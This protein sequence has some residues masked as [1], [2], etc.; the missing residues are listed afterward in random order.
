MRFRIAAMK[1]VVSSSLLHL[2]S[3]KNKVSLLSMQVSK[4][5]ALLES[6]ETLLKDK[7]HHIWSS[8]L[9]TD[10]LRSKAD[11]QVSCDKYKPYSFSWRAA[12]QCSPYTEGC[13]G[14]F[15]Y[16]TY[17]MF[18]EVGVPLI[19]DWNKDCDINVYNHWKEISATNTSAAEWDARQSAEQANLKTAEHA[20]N[21]LNNQASKGSG[22]A[23]VDPLSEQALGGTPCQWNSCY[24]SENAKKNLVFASDYN[25]IGG[26]SQGGSEEW[27]KRHLHDH[28]PVVVSMN[29]GVIGNQFFWHTGETVLISEVEHLKI[30]PRPDN[31]N[32]RH[33]AALTHAVI[34][35]GYGEE[36]MTFP[37]SEAPD[38]PK[39]QASID[40]GN[41]CQWKSD[42][43]ECECT[44]TVP[45][46]VSFSS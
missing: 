20:T 38:E 18:H 29:T 24:T 15:S 5:R 44:V 25:Y 21:Q 37:D 10:E 34:A 27:I 32:I 8:S 11:R 19:S 40:Q 13:A 1:R 4:S 41:N 33:W 2:E 39:C 9:F 14:G 28:G 3:K 45:Y 36:D 23:W 46:W 31:P 42:K 30:E 16:L 7:L 6:K 17:K 12:F 26:F 22:K 35:V 43:N